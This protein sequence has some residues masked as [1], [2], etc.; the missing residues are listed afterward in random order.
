METV[1][2]ASTGSKDLDANVDRHTVLIE[3]VGPVEVPGARPVQ[4]IIFGGR[5]F[6]HVADDADGRWIYRLA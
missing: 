3:E 1:L 6:T 2:T 5:H 4:S